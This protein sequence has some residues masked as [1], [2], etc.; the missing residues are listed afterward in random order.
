MK[1]AWLK[2]VLSVMLILA[3]AVTGCSSGKSG[4]S[5][6]DGTLSPDNP[7]TFSWLVYD[8]VEGK[9]RDDW[10]IFKEIEAKTGVKIEFQ[11]V[12]QEG[13]EE[14][15]QI[16]IA[17]NTATDF[18]HVSTQEGRENGPEKIFLNLK[19]YLDRAPNLKAFFEQNPEAEAVAK[20]ADGGLYTV[21]MLEGDTE[22]KGFNFVWYAR[23]DLLDKD[24]ITPPTTVD[25]FYNYLK[26]LKEKNPDS[27]PL[28]SNAVIG[29]TGLYTTFGR[30]FTGVHGFY[31]ID[32]T[33]DEYAFAP[34]HSGYKDML[35]FLN[36]LYAEKLLDP[37]YSL[38]TQAQWEERILT[39][40]SLVTF[41]WKADMEAMIAKARSAG[42]A[43]YDLDATPMFAADGIKNYQ[44][45]RPIVGTTGRAISAKVKDKE[46]AVQFLD[47]LVG[48]EGRNYLSLGIEGKTYTMEDGKPVYNPDFGTSPFN[49]L[50]KDWGVWYDQITLNNAISREVWERGLSEK[51][52]DINARYADL[53]IP[54]P[55]QIVK[56]EEELELEKSKLSNL[57]K[58]LEQKITEFVTGKTPMTD[59]AYQQFIDQAKKLGSD[60]LLDMYN[61]AYKRT[62][63]K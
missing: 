3:L 41:F 22:G 1:R 21:P 5:N 36:K 31:N 35:I 51:S 20:G 19:D 8:R 55:K 34:Y 32:P 15:R 44:Y 37:E 62:Y 13:I 58:F 39:G 6:G 4:S 26:T 43:D 12:S 18:I 7:I 24:N 53:I 2:S 9:V 59:A 40:K 17:T 25:E 30:V 60:E 29:D 10:E 38:L 28:I 42:I 61:T 16:M 45:S 47:Y 56:T 54:A 49:T 14:K 46:R 48:E 52:K 11:V 33:T 57:N 63:S 27:Y 50:R 23:K